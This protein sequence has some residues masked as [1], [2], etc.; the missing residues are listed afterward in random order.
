MAAKSHIDLCLF[1]QILEVTEDRI[2]AELIP[3]LLS[4]KSKEFSPAIDRIRGEQSVRSMF[5]DEQTNLHESIH[6][7]Q[8][9]IYPF[10]RWY[11][12]HSFTQII[13]A[14]NEYSEVAEAANEGMLTLRSPGFYILDDYWSMWEKGDE[15]I[16]ESDSQDDVPHG[17]R[18]VFTFNI[19]DLIENSA[20]LI[21][22]KMST[23]NDFPSWTEYNRWSKR[24]PAYTAVLDFVRS[25]LDDNDIALRIFC[26]LVQVSF[27]T[28]KPTNAFAFLLKAFKVQLQHGHLDVILRQPEP[29]R[30]LEIFDEFLSKSRIREAEGDDYGDLFVD[31]FIRLDRYITSNFTRGGIGH[32]VLSDFTKKWGE[33]EANDLSFRYALTAP[34]G[35]R[36]QLLQL[37]GIFHDPITL[38][39][40]TIKGQNVVALAGDWQPNGRNPQLFVDWLAIYGVVRRWVNA[41]MDP[42]FRL[43]HHKSCPHYDQNLC[44]MWVLIPDRFEDCRFPDRIKRLVEDTRLKFRGSPHGRK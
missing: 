25:Y 37:E 21:Q 29:C 28:N 12:F 39:K 41:L 1:V 3:S 32:P 10:L 40:F 13:R 11:G 23:G 7:F 30:W 20:S 24:N 18:K 15:L 34:V 36:K 17:F 38:L 16:V 5:V 14:F 42:S 8:A 31:K 19:T 43:C 44:N 22:F 26:P 6:I 2:P 9:V 33:L 4:R 27:E 35:Y